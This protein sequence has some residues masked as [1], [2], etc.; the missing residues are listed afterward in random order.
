M[1]CKTL[2]K[3]E[4]VEKVERKKK[5]KNKQKIIHTHNKLAGANFLPDEWPV[6]SPIQRLFRDAWTMYYLIYNIVEKKHTSQTT[7]HRYPLNYSLIITRLLLES[8]HKSFRVTFAKKSH[9]FNC[10]SCWYL[11]KNIYIYK[12]GKKTEWT[13]ATTSLATIHINKQ[14]FRPCNAFL[15]CPRKNKT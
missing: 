7:S 9:S 2:I 12:K 4:T 1:K 5:D 6:N 11:R 15:R 13:V 8:L 3:Y 14:T 10:R